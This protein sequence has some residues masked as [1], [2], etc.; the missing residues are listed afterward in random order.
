[1]IKV[2][3]GLYYKDL[4]EK[5]KEVIYVSLRSQVKKSKWIAIAFELSWKDYKNNKF[6][7][8]G[9]TFVRENNNEFWEVA[10]FIHDWLNIIGYVG[11]GVDLYF[12]KIMLE[13][14][15]PENIIFERCK[16]MQWTFLNVF[17]HKI[18]GNFVSSDIPNFLKTK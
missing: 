9:A 6:K 10:S 8:D 15:Y 4:E 13:L 17:K 16:W 12:I 14:R 7:Y 18:N 3:K 11:K 5:D 2:D 1:M